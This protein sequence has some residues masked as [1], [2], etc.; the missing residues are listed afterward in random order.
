MLKL[1][2]WLADHGEAPHMGHLFTAFGEDRGPAVV[3][4]LTGEEIKPLGWQ[5]IDLPYQRLLEAAKEIAA[6]TKRTGKRPHGGTT[7][8]LLSW[9]GC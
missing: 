6:D 5:K 3:R 4:H 7:P 8:G 9:W 1:A 2:K